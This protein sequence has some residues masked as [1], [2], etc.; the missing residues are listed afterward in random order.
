[1]LG[2]VHSLRAAPRDANQL[3]VTTDRLDIVLIDLSFSTATDGR[4]SGTARCRVLDRSPLE[5]GIVNASFSPCGGWLAYT[6][7]VAASISTIRLL[8]L[9]GIGGANV[10]SIARADVL[11]DVN[12]ADVDGV[13]NAR[14]RAPIDA[15][16]PLFSSRCASWGVNGDY[17]YFIS[18][19]TWRPQMDALLFA[20]HFSATDILVA[21]PLRH[22][23]PNPF[24]R[25]A[26]PPGWSPLSDTD[27]DGGEEQ[28][29]EEEEEEE[30][31]EGVVEDEGEL[32]EDQ[33]ESKAGEAKESDVYS[34]DDDG[35]EG[36]RTD[37]DGEGVG[38]AATEDEETRADSEAKSGGD[39]ED[40]GASS[41]APRAL[42]ID[43]DGIAQ[44]ACAF[45]LATGLYS[46]L[47]A[48]AGRKV[49]Y[50]RGS[51]GAR[52]RATMGA[53][54]AEDV[55]EGEEAAAEELYTYD[56]ACEREKCLGEVRL[57][58]LILNGAAGHM[59]V[60]AAEEGGDDSRLS[61]H[62]AGAS[63]E[64]GGGDESDDEDGGGGADEPGPRTGVIDCERLS[65][66]IHP[67]AEWRRLLD[68]AW[69][70]LTTTCY[71]PALAENDDWRAVHARCAALIT[72]V[73][74][75]TEVED[76][77]YELTSALGVSH[78]KP[79]GGMDCVGASKDQRLA[80]GQGSLGIDGFFDNEIQLYRICNV[81][82]GDA[83]A[84]DAARAWGDAASAPNARR[85]PLAAVGMDV[86]EGDCVV[87]INHTA[88]HVACSLPKALC[89]LAG[90][91]VVVS[92][93]AAAAVAEASA[94][95]GRAA[96]RARACLS[97]GAS[98]Q[99]S[100]TAAAAAA[101]AAAQ[102]GAP[103]SAKT[104]RSVA[105][106]EEETK[107]ET[108]TGKK[109]E[110]KTQKKSR[111]GKFGERSS[112]TL[113]AD[114]AAGEEDAGG[115]A[116]ES[117]VVP[118]SSMLETI[119]A[120][121]LDAARAA[122][123]Q[124]IASTAACVAHRLAFAASIRKSSREVRTKVVPA[125]QL[126]AARYQD[127]VRARRAEVHAAGCGRVGYVHVPDNDA[128]GFA[129]FH[130]SFHVEVATREA[131]VVDARGNTG[132]YCSELLLRSLAETPRTWEVPRY[133][134][135]N[136]TPT[137][138]LVSGQATLLVDHATSSDAEIMALHFRRLGSA[139]SPPWQIVGSRT[140]GGVLT[141]ESCTLVDGSTMSNAVSANA[142]VG[143]ASEDLG[144]GH[145]VI[146]ENVGIIPDVVVAA[147]AGAE[148]DAQLRAAVRV[149][150]KALAARSPLPVPHMPRSRFATHPAV[151]PRTVRHLRAEDVSR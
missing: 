106:R 30:E 54:D 141:T 99:S 127:W 63:L 147:K 64:G 88:L 56:F 135:C 68:E 27:D 6:Y 122:G 62:V 48:I 67:L 8:A 41:S 114:D 2:E 92:V 98:P 3:V 7:Y 132:G 120:I 140:W 11:L 150:S 138:A 130:R 139:K 113:E 53:A 105:K 143:G 108:K 17:L 49:M 9:E 123:D 80:N 95:A 37:E 78:T 61:A 45:P 128:A 87:A 4:V 83:W 71:D 34:A 10:S 46:G 60:H 13:N 31:D 90:Q 19:R 124:E 40:E 79:A 5:P 133:G 148:G 50:T 102:G 74:C 33:E 107:T 142:F 29:P 76:V 82:R 70:F 36:S 137:A 89:D 35:D 85:G 23:V 58:E 51:V 93:V 112:P 129:A 101:A 145:H 109:T 42:R 117:V 126:T 125:E 116:R 39:I 75:R 146:I 16:D 69:R 134:A 103:E 91:E 47:W 52:H 144:V 72:R 44:R 111:K 25:T 136:P 59:L 14:A 15:T 118:T 97:E 115:A 24:T 18:Q 149:A 131:I 1:M 65:V 55:E 38:A 77:L 104:T 26:R 100:R 96:A 12:D 22:D 119:V 66:V 57:R 21:L 43:A 73:S 94:A 81:V 86:H 20:F 151:F 32:R 110:K 121:A 84:S 28:E